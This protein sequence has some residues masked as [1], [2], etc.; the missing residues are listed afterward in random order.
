LATYSN[1]ILFRGT[2][3]CIPIMYASE[4]LE[5]VNLPP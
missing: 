4:R 3:V 2:A 5:M 1:W